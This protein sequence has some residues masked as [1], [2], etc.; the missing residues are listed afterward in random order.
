MKLLKHIDA[1]LQEWH[2]RRQDKKHAE[3]VEAM[4]IDFT[5][6]AVDVALEEA[7]KTAHIR[8]AEQGPEFEFEG[9]TPEEIQHIVLRSF[10]LRISEADAIE[11]VTAR[12]G[13]FGFDPAAVIRTPK[14][15]NAK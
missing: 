13:F 4:R 5:I 2:D 10:G 3:W 12:L 15:E 11:I 9:I 6:R 14:K 7:V 1:F 8:M